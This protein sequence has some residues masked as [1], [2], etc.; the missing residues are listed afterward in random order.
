MWQRVLEALGGDADLESLL[1][2]S[3]IVQDHQHAAGAKGGRATDP[4]GGLV[5][6]KARKYTLP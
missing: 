4:S 6:V 5:A 3:T 1:L 2:D